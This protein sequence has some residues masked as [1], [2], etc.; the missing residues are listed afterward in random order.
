M[1]IKTVTITGADDNTDIRAMIELSKKFPFVEWGLL[2]SPNPDRKGTARYPS[3]AWIK[4]LQRVLNLQMAIN[5]E[6]LNFCAHFCGGYMKEF[7]A[8]GSMASALSDMCDINITRFF[9]RYQY[10]FNAQSIVVCKEFWSHFGR[11]SSPVIIQLNKNNKEVC[12]TLIVEVGY[13]KNVQF[14][15]DASG[16]L[17][18]SPKEWGMPVENHFTGYA[19]GL[20]PDNLEEQLLKINEVAKDNEIWIDAETGLRTDDKLDLD[21]VTKFLEIAKKYT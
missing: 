17:G 19:G 2:F 20:T 4:K 11:M 18:I 5:G 16:G 12:E 21:K 8:S 6:K 3:I 7:L 15:H 9:N 14:L 13:N 1:K 10:N